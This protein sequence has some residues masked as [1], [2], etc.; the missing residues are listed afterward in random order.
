MAASNGN[1]RGA[2]MDETRRRALD[3]LQPSG[4][5]TVWSAWRGAERDDATTRIE[6]AG[7]WPVGATVGVTEDERCGVCRARVGPR[8]VFCPECGATL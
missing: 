1:G 3:P 5:E 8:D 2:P 4:D 6:V 7:Q